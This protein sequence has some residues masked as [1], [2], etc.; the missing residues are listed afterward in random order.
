LNGPFP[1]R[2]V[3]SRGVLL[4]SSLQQRNK[5]RWTDV[6][7]KLSLDTLTITL[8][9]RIPRQVS[10]PRLVKLA[11]NT[12]VAKGPSEGGRFIFTVSNGDKELTFASGTE[13][14][15]N[16][17]IDQ[18]DS[19]LVMLRQC[20]SP[21][22]P[23]FPAPAPATSHYELRPHEFAFSWFRS[24]SLPQ[25]VKQLPKQRLPRMSSVQ[26]DPSKAMVN[27][28]GAGKGLK[29]RGDLF[30]HRATFSV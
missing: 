18:L 10:Q 13:V 1:L 24:S 8:A 15:R 28:S 23:L 19:C 9:S 11:S 7:M 26:V 21:L 25:L 30:L 5:F 3:V 22:I 29:G 2:S 4:E 17:W 20:S 6:N 16:R 12:C 27:V 14:E